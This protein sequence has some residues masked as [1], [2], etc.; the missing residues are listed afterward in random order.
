MNSNFKQITK[1]DLEC[2]FNI[3]EFAEEVD[4]NGVK[5]KVVFNN[6]GMEEINKYDLDMIHD[7][8]ILL[9]CKKQ[10]LNIRGLSK[11]RMNKKMYN[12]ISIIELG[13]IYKILLGTK[14]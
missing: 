3:D 8:Q 5:L 7:D 9:Y 13:E 2:F 1:N 14:S 11:V 4:F 6:E 12:I 10:D